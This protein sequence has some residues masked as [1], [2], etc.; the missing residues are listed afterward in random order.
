MQHSSEES[1]TAHRTTPRTAHRTPHT[2]HRTPHTAHRTPHTAHRAARRGAVRCCT[3]LRCAA[4]RCAALRCAAQC[5]EHSAQRTAQSR[6]DQSTAL[7]RSSSATQHSRLRGG[8]ATEAQPRERGG[9]GC[10]QPWRRVRRDPGGPGILSSLPKHNTKT[11]CFLKGWTNTHYKIHRF[12]ICGRPSVSLFHFPST[13]FFICSFFCSNLSTF[14]KC[15][16]IF[17]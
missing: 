14:M 4:L 1:R 15:F 9:E 13:I 6:A 2:A 16:D 3:A 10:P 11:S 7:Q 8:G 5:T 17:V 12:C